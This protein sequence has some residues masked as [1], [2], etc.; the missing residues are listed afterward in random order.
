M[1]TDEAIIILRQI[2]GER[3]RLYDR[4]IEQVIPFI[5]TA[6]SSDTR[7]RIRRAIDRSINRKNSLSG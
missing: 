4:R 7:E 5:L 1:I 6:Q 3:R 2:F